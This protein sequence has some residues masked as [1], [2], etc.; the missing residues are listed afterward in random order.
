MTQ[1]QSGPIL[2]VVNQH[3][4]V[5]ENPLSPECLTEIYRNLAQRAGLPD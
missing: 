5:S 1:I 4:H 3:G 2:S